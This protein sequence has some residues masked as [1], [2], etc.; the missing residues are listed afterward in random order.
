MAKKGPGGPV[1]GRVS[2]KVVP[3]TSNFRDDVKRAIRKGAEGLKVVVPGELD[4]ASLLRDIRKKVKAVN[5]L[6][7]GSPDYWLRF[8]GVVEFDEDQIRKGLQDLKKGFRAEF[9]STPT[10]RQDRIYRK[11]NPFGEMGSIGYKDILDDKSARKF[12]T[13][14]GRKGGLVFTGS[15]RHAWGQFWDR[16]NHGP[17]LR[18]RK[19]FWEFMTTPHRQVLKSGQVIVRDSIL[20]GLKGAQKAAEGVSRRLW[21][22]V[23][24]VGREKVQKGL[25]EG[26]RRAVGPGGLG[27]VKAAFGKR[28]VQAFHRFKVDMADLW[29]EI[30]P[31]GA[32][33]LRKHVAPLGRKFGEVW[34]REVSKTL[35]QTYREV[36]RLYLASPQE[37]MRRLRKMAGEF[38]GFMDRVRNHEW[39]QWVRHQKRYITSSPTWKAAR[40]LGQT[41]LHKV[42]LHKP[43][44]L[45][46]VAGLKGALGGVRA[47][48][49][50]VLNKR[51]VVKVRGQLKALLGKAAGGVYGSGK[52]FLARL[53]GVRL[54]AD[55]TD[56]TL[57]P[58]RELDRMLPLIAVGGVAIAQLGAA[59]VSAAVNVFSLSKGLAEMVPALLVMPGFLASAAVAFVTFGSAFRELDKKVPE[60]TKFAGAI[61][62][63]ISRTFWVGAQKPLKE[64]AKTLLPQLVSG[65]EK[66]GKAAGVLTGKLAD[67]FR[68]IL[69]PQMGKMFDGVAKGFQ[70][71]EAGTPGLAK[72]VTYFGLLGAD[73]LPRASRWL[74]DLT[75]KLGAWVQKGYETGR[76]HQQI[77]LAI[78]RW[79]EF[80]GVLQGVWGVLSAISKAAEAA[81]GSTLKSLGDGLK[82][83]AGKLHSPRAQS[84]MQ[85]LFGG[86]KQAIKEAKRIASQ[87]ATAFAEQ[88]SHTLGRVLPNTGG[89]FGHLSKGLLDA[90]NHPS[91]HKGLEDLSRQL[92]DTFKDLEP[93][94]RGMGPGIGA[95]L[96]LVKDALEALTPPVQVLLDLFNKLG[97]ENG[98]A[99][100][101]ALKDI[102][103][104]LT[105]ILQDL[106][107]AFQELSPV[108]QDFLGTTG[109]ELKELFESLRPH[110]K[111]F[112]DNWVQ[113]IKDNWPTIKEALS[114][115]KDLLEKLLP[116]LMSISDTIGGFT[117]GVITTGLALL[118]AA[119]EGDTE[120]MEEILEDAGRKLKKGLENLFNAALT[121]A[122]KKL[123]E[124]SAAF[125]QL[126]AEL[127]DILIVA[128]HGALSKLF[129]NPVSD[130][131][132]KID[133]LWG[134]MKQA[135]GKAGEEAD[136][137]RNRIKAR[138]E[139]MIADMR[140]W[141]ERTKTHLREV[142]AKGDQGAK[143]MLDALER[144]QAKYESTDPGP[145]KDK[146]WEQLQ[147]MRAF[148]ESEGSEMLEDL[149]EAYKKANPDEMV[150]KHEAALLD[151][152]EK[153][154]TTSTGMVEP[155]N[156]AYEGTDPSKMSK[157]LSE[158]FQEMQAEAGGFASG[159]FAGTVNSAYQS[160]DP[161]SMLGN[162]TD[163]MNEM[164]AKA[165]SESPKIPTAVNGAFSQV[166]P[167]PMLS[168]LQGTM[169]SM[170]GE[171]RSKAPQTTQSLNG[172][173]SGVRPGLM[174]PA[175]HATM[176]QFNAAGRKGS[177]EFSGEMESGMRRA[178]GGV[179]SVSL[180]G[181]GRTVIGSLVSGIRSGFG[182][183]RSTLG[184]LTRLIPSW[185]GP[186]P[187]D[188]KLLHKPADL[189]MGGFRDQLKA[190]FGSIFELLQQ[191]SR[192]LAATE[193]EMP[194]VRQ[195]RVEPPV[196]EPGDGGVP[197]RGVAGGA[198][199]AQVNVHVNQYNPVQERDSVMVNRA[200]QVAAA[201]FG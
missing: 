103:E 162:L 190:N 98:G 146:L 84:A 110:I 199:G 184:A 39:V 193:F 186:A 158:A 28:I 42:Q 123:T 22:R 81:G 67:A 201:V 116:V 132:A 128:L 71:L 41:V 49:H 170:V 105:P 14:E 198:G 5:V 40:I 182:V 63:A 112:V 171:V 51:S 188:R 194:Q 31:K 136:K 90:L 30:D 130:F 133:P 141:A 34:N 142:A 20:D 62:K 160:T 125:I 183:V 7:R 46:A 73:Y 23:G 55:I 45:K 140:S 29:E 83:T 8:R 56:K 35:R 78:T 147:Q 96:N 109:K 24:R 177:S 154:S 113:R 85:A 50:A 16:F 53:T 19:R 117:F 32:E 187:V 197:G 108:F 175:V 94:I 44:L 36:K 135:W 87:S 118:N 150:K 139:A 6:L 196:W 131:M 18:M 93:T 195:G 59:A 174:M 43:S 156:R 200:L 167:Q 181:A 82:E 27:G 2:I 163:T 164:V 176:W 145:M 86:S 161:K 173:F 25:E 88:F 185:K 80:W 72:T 9:V 159:P 143:Q 104:G 102:S 149:N 138:Q 57:K 155:L 121:L 64:F 3:D 168:Q 4:S 33:F 165:R 69:V 134:A 107:D 66:S 179:R 11:S 38:Q 122:Q 21:E 95:G 47:Q 191:F 111:E 75:N 37:Q 74:S 60:F 65:F 144:L 152:K 13:A 52:A 101:G 148:M 114:N 189:I 120:K 10:V 1:V 166:K 58:L 91:V 12:F 68:T 169:H 61:E 137:A 119:L 15:F 192:D 76:L 77:E 106:S 157:K 129:D 89:A 115:L 54:L 92:K 70:A 180:A 151:M 124:L 79:K 178:A 172:A 99:L 127:R 48:V 126:F 153:T 97:A 100:G 17:G 26:L